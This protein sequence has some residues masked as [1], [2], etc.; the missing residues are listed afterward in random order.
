METVEMLVNRFEA[1][2][3]WTQALLADFSDW[4]W[5]RQPGAGLHHAAWIA[6][7]LTW[8]EWGLVNARCLGKAGTPPVSAELFGKGSK[9]LDDA[10]KYPSPGQ[11][12]ADM[13]RVHGEMIPI[14]RAMTPAFLAEK[15]NGDPHPYFTTKG[16]VIGMLSMHESFHA[17]QLALLRRLMGRGALR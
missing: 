8:A 6:G 5:F 4:E 16:E 13:D 12:R 9:P 7:H 1:A 14:I 17:G 11:I 2:R 3:R 15:A 10:G